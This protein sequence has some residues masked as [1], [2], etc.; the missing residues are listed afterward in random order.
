[1]VTSEREQRTVT[2]TDGSSSASD[3]MAAPKPTSSD[4]NGV[5]TD[6]SCGTSYGR[7]RR[8]SLDQT[9]TAT[10][11]GNVRHM[12]GNYP[13]SSGTPKHGNPISI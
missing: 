7:R 9:M 10:M 8:H 11:D 3:A 12:G 4:G 5:A 13:I 2:S 1:M 6:G